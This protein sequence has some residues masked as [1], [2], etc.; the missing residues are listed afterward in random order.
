MSSDLGIFSSD[1]DPALD[2]YFQARQKKRY[3]GTWFDHRHLASDPAS[4]EV[5]A[6]DDEAEEKEVDDLSVVVER[7][8]D[9]T[10]QEVSLEEGCFYRER[11]LSDEA[12]LDGVPKSVS[13]RKATSAEAALKEADLKHEIECHIDD[14]NE[15]IDLSYVVFTPAGLA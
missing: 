7:E 13:S 3:V 4:A 12:Q 8:E 5:E 10:L 14:G 11:S 1:D 9:D 15:M 6:H 2:N